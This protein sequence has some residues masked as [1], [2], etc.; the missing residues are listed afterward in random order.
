MGCVMGTLWIGTSFLHAV[1]WRNCTSNAHSNAYS[2]FADS[3]LGHSQQLYT[4][5]L[6]TWGGTGEVAQQVGTLWLMSSTLKSVTDRGRHAPRMKG[7]TGKNTGHWKETRGHR[8]QNK[9]NKKTQNHDNLLLFLTLSLSR[10]L[11]TA[12]LITLWRLLFSA[13]W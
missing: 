9:R 10:Y 5:T 13:G 1:L 3:E 8:I 11:D 12:S 6:M 2:K 7:K 4:Q